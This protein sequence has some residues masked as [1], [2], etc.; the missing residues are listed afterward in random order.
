LTRSFAFER[1]T[2]IF[3]TTGYGFYHD[4]YVKQDGRW[5]IQRVTLE[6]TIRFGTLVSLNPV[7][8]SAEQ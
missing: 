2:A 6:K 7:P 1:G 4:E 5:L 3:W 8:S